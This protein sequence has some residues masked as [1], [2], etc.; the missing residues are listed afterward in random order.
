MAFSY[1]PFNAPVLKCARGCHMWSRVD[2]TNAS[3]DTNVQ[4]RF[5]HV[6]NDNAIIL[7]AHATPHPNIPNNIT[8]KQ[9]VDMV[10]TD[11][12]INEMIRGTNDY[13]FDHQDSMSYHGGYVPLP[14]NAL[15]RSTMRLYV[16]CLM[17]MAIKNLNVRQFFRNTESNGVAW[18]SHKIGTL[19]NSK[20]A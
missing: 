18:L 20:A 1:A 2:T 10:L 4:P 14:V 3:T 8:Y 16:C 9:L 11:S 19:S 6:T 7:N 17:M 15:G 13:G 12:V 5:L